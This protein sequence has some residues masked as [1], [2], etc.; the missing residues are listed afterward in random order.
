MKIYGIPG[1]GCTNQYF[2]FIDGAITFDWNFY[3]PNNTDPKKFIQEIKEDFIFICYS[4]G[5]L[6]IS[7]A[8]KN[9]H[10]KG[11][12]SL[13]GFINFCGDG[14][15]RA[16][17]QERIKRMQLDLKNNPLKTVQAFNSQA[18]SPLPTDESTPAFV[19]LN[20][21]LNLLK[22]C[23]QHELQCSVP[24]LLIRGRKDTILHPKVAVQL[25][26]HLPNAE[27]Y[28]IDQAPHDLSHSKEV[29]EYITQFIS[30]Y[31]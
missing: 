14:K 24:T 8:V 16:V 31:S 23:D 10:C 30:K 9:S 4:T 21:G 7:D 25:E 27:K 6:F 17:L 29:R 5:S 11:V 2:N 1:W 15:L 13:S 19:N 22:D 12:I 28:C 26:R 20:S 18:Q 3:S